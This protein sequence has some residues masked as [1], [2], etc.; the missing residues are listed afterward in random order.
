MFMNSKN[1]HAL[2]KTL[3]TMLFAGLFALSCSAVSWA[4]EVRI[5]FVDIQKAIAGTQ[6]FKKKFATFKQSFKKENSV[7]AAKEERIRKELEKLNKQ[8]FALSPDVKRK[9]EEKF[10]KDKLDFERYV[11]D[12]NAEFATKE[13][14]ITRK[15]LGQMVDVIKKIGKEK[16]FT[17]I[18]ESKTALYLTE[19]IDLTNQVIK[20]YDRA[21]K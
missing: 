2:Q 14:A 18:V 15:I 19:A 21:Y 5:G 8:S 20:S 12:K 13:K 1:L 4:A 3:V 7:I 6:A 9:K 17:M 11:Q 16:N 10:R